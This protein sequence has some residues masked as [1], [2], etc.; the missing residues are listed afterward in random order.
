VNFQYAERHRVRIHRELKRKL[1]QDVLVIQVLEYGSDKA[2]R[3]TA[4]SKEFQLTPVY[5][6]QFNS[7]ARLRISKLD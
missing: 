5:E 6:T 4:L 3:G 7:T 1:Y 2:I